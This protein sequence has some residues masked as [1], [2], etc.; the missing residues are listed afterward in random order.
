MPEERLCLIDSPV[1]ILSVPAAPVRETSPLS[2]EV[3][4]G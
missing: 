3:I 4:H 2:K 1:F